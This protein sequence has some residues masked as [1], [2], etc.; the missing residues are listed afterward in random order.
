MFADIDETGRVVTVAWLQTGYLVV[1]MGSTHQLFR[2]GPAKTVGGAPTEELALHAV[3]LWGGRL[4]LVFASETPGQVAIS[5][6]PV[7][8]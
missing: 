4:H 2:T 5:I 3:V 6:T 1:S 7:P 8:Q